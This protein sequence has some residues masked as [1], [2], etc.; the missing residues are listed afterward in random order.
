M[1]TIIRSQPLKAL[2]EGVTGL[3]GQ[4]SRPI[5][6]TST[7][8]DVVIEQGLAVIQTARC[9]QNNENVPIEAVLTFPVPFDAVLTGLH[10]RVDERRLVAVAKPRKE[11]RG[12]YEQ[13]LDR[14]KLAV[15]HEEALRGVHI[16]SIGQ[17]A[18]GN[19]VEI[20]SEMTMPLAIVGGAPLLRIPMTVGQ[21]YGQS[22]LLPADDLIAE[23]GPRWATFTLRCDSGVP[24]FS[25]GAPLRGATMQVALDRA[26]EVAIPGAAFGVRDG[27]DARGRRVELSLAATATGDEPIETAILFDR[28]GSTDNALVGSG[29]TVWQ[30][31]RAGLQSA[32]GELREGDRV[33]L[34]QFD[35]K[36]E[37]LGNADS[38]KALNLVQFIDRPG[39]GTELG[40]AVRAAIGAG[41]R[42]ILVITDGKTWASE[43][44]DIASHR[45]RI[46]GVLVGGDSLDAMIGHLAALTGGH[47]FAAAQNGVESAIESALATMRSRAERLTGRIHDDWPESL[48]VCRGGVS[49]A[50]KW[51]EDS[52]GPDADSAGRFAAALALPLL[53]EEA[54]SAFAASHGLCTHLTSLIL[55]DEAGGEAQGVPEMRKVPLATPAGN[56]SFAH[57][58]PCAEQPYAGFAEQRAPRFIQASRMPSIEDLP[59]RAQFLPRAKRSLPPNPLAGLARSIEWDRGGNALSMGD[60]SSLSFWVRMRVKLL[61]RLPA[62][63][64]LAMALQKDAALVVIGL[65][66]ELVADTDRT[67]ARLARLIVDGA[68]DSLLQDARVALAKR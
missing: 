33:M 27:R 36:P 4:D 29:M 49:I 5:P 53:E 46:S 3:V 54:A 67:A 13:A 57:M 31:M 23:D 51:V 1:V 20:V 6:L 60:L 35:D 68:P 7:R 45:V 52:E 61:G 48:V 64:A 47:V 50:V 55:I 28:S 19:S 38:L 22:P 30:A 39:G 59:L 12:A 34:W 63:R 58:P 2:R 24:A 16:L 62:L 32:L 26:V 11:A 37:L 65:L 10:A 9:F 8:I 40:A 66:A 44:H 42:D 17:L 43:V 56:I 41:A 25:D 15:L 18:P 14:G 21:I